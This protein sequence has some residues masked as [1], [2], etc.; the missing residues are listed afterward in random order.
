VSSVERVPEVAGVRVTTGDMVAG[1]RAHGVTAVCRGAL[2][3]SRSGVGASQSRALG[4]QLAL[5]AL[6]LI[7][8][9]TALSAALE[10]DGIDRVRSWPARGPLG[11]DPGEVDNPRDR[12]VAQVNEALPGPVAG[13]QTEV[14]VLGGLLLVLFLVF[15]V[16]DGEGMWRWVLGRAPDRW[17]LHLDGVGR[18][19][20]IVVSRYVSGIVTVTAVDGVRIGAGLLMVGVPPWL[21]LAAH[22]LCE[23]LL[24]VPVA[25]SRP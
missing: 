19:A 20:W 14:S 16:K 2:R 17:R 11:L 3:R 22:D 1:A 15:F 25:E 6:P 23:Q 12:L 18:R 21:S 4:L 7:I 13:A 8:A 10:A 24:S 9:L 5:A